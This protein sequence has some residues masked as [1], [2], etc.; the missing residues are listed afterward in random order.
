MQEFFFVSMLIF[1]SFN[2]PFGF[3]FRAI[4]LMLRAIHY[5]LFYSLKHQLIYAFLR[6]SEILE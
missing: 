4:E 3:K 2:L 5:H 1:D 6:K